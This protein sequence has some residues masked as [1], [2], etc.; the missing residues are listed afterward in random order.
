MSTMPK[1]VSL[2]NYSDIHF[3]TD[4][5]ASTF[6]WPGKFWNLP[7]ALVSFSNTYLRRQKYLT[8]MFAHQSWTLKGACVMVGM[9]A[10]D[11]D[12]V[13]SFSNDMP[14]IAIVQNVP[15]RLM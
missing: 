2:K 5:F 11:L 7:V 12:F 13:I 10:H 8:K 6:P 9:A 1:T 4:G 15:A 14:V 3:T